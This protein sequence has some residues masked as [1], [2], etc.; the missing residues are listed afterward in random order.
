MATKTNFLELTLPDNG[1]YV[2]NWDTVVNANFEELDEHLDD[3]NTDLV[4]TTG[5]TG[6]LKGTK[7]SLE[8]RLDEGLN[9][10]GTPNLD[11]SP[12]FEALTRSEVY[13][14][15]SSSDQG[16]KVR[17]RFNLAEIEVAK[18]RASFDQDRFGNTT[19]PEAATGIAKLANR[20]QDVSDGVQSPV[21]GFTP[22]TV[23]EGTATGSTPTYIEEN[24]LYI[25]LKGGTII[26][27]DGYYFE[28]PGDM[29]VNFTTDISGV[30]GTET[31]YLYATRNENDFLNSDRP[32]S[33]LY[34]NPLGADYTLDPRIIPAN[35]TQRASPSVAPTTGTI[36]SSNPDRLTTTGSSFLSY[37]VRA[38]D[39]LQ[40]LS[41]SSAI[42]GDYVIKTV[43][44][45][46]E[47]DIF[48]EFQFPSGVTTI[49]NVEHQI[50]R[51]NHPA[52]GISSTKTYTEGRTYIGEADITAANFT[53]VRPYAFGGIYD[54]G[55]IACDSAGA[56]T[57]SLTNHYLGVVPTQVEV[58]FRGDSPERYLLNPPSGIDVQH[59]DEIGGTTWAV[60]T[61]P[62][63][64]IQITANE[65][66][67]G[68][69][70]INP[71]TPASYFYD[72]SGGTPAHITT[73][74]GTWDIRVIL[75]R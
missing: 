7:T 12:D 60:T 64:G 48:G 5:A 3:L 10:D 52:L 17:Q 47:L 30:A 29:V 20:Y 21:R 37:G 28:V 27:I 41:Q 66:Q 44:G 43:S 38:G 56:F 62:I 72:F 68:L 67:F 8:E 26:N 54:T 58:W 65:S 57:N 23:V 75:R 55:W 19:N 24:A 39:I 31:W 11:N 63:Q 35:T 33:E 46:N 51:P 32:F 15:G 36:V 42:D 14:L 1:E 71:Q 74:T 4:G 34:G 18:I 61:T 40:I 13:S 45:D 70:L 2:D 49:A 25:T 53:A 9:S 50:W 6:N 22:G 16:K 59:A 69:Y 73:S